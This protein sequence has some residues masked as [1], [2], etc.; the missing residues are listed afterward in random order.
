MYIIHEGERVRITYNDP[1]RWGPAHEY[2]GQNRIYEIEATV[3]HVPQD[4]G[5]MWYFDDG[6]TV[7]AQ[8]PMSS[9]LDKIV[10]VEQD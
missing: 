3:L 8:N 5:D 7:F 1:F 9:N 10:K 4:T 6:E 2:L